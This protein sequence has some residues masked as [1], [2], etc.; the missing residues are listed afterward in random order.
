[1]IT[2]QFY[3]HVKAEHTAQ[4]AESFDRLVATVGHR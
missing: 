1:M 4:V 3:G 2:A